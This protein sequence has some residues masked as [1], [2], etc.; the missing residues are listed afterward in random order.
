LDGIRRTPAVFMCYTT[1]AVEPDRTFF[2]NF[3]RF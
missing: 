3:F 1:G 2:G